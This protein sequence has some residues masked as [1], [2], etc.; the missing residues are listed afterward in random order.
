MSELYYLYCHTNLI[1]DKKYFGVTCR[2]PY[3]RWGNNGCNYKTSPHFYSAIQ[4]YGWD[5]FNHEIL[6]T[7]DNKSEVEEL[8]RYYILEYKTF[9]NKYGYNV[10]LGGSYKGKHSEETKRKI[11]ESKIGKHRSEE[12][13]EKISNGLIGKIVGNKNSQ[14]KP[15]ICITTHKIY[16]SQRLASKDTGVYQSDISRCCSGKI[17]SAGKNE[18]GE[19]LVW[20]YYKDYLE[21]GGLDSCEKM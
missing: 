9:D 4:K 19:R 14:S 5:N 18:L 20:M 3:K 12:T 6:K 10:E 8:E 7:T 16:E 13:K 15:V 21:K 11:S 1:N 17:K 2:I